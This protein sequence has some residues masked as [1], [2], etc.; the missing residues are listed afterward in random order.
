MKSYDY[1]DTDLIAGDD[2]L[3]AASLSL[4]AWLHNC[5]RA[6]LSQKLGPGGRRRP[7]LLKLSDIQDGRSG[8]GVN[9][10]TCGTA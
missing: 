4:A 6:S 10:E 8:K 3:F 5:D 2:F 9:R 7:L 1:V